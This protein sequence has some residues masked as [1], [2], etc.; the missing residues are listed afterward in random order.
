MRY[1]DV[2][3]LNFDILS[4]DI[5]DSDKHTV[6]TY[7]VPTGYVSTSASFF[8]RDLDTIRGGS[9]GHRPKPNFFTY[10][11]QPEPEPDLSPESPV[12]FSSPEK[13]RAQSMKPEPDLS[14]KQNLDP[15]HL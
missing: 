10:L 6:H 12:N 13:T 14:P 1:F 7:A 5:P 11:V 3:N 9:V 2:Y 8:K 15:T 4:F